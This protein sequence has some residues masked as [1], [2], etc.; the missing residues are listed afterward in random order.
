MG[1]RLEDY[2][3]ELRERYGDDERAQLD[4]AMCRFDLAGQLLLLRLAAGITQKQVAERSGI[5][6]AE[7]SRYERGVGNPTQ[8]TIEALA[9]ALDAHIELVPDQPEVETAAPA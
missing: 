9:R 2:I 4:A 3:D 6:Q 5:S 8:S 7:V 1:T